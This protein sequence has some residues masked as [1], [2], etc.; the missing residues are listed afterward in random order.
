M[1]NLQKWGFMRL[2]DVYD[3]RVADIEAERIDTAVFESAMMFSRDMQSMMD[4]LVER[5]TVREGSFDLPTAG[6][7]QPLSEDGTPR[8]T[9]SYLTIT[10][11]YPMW[12]GGDSFGLNR[13]AYAVLTVREMEKLMV[14]VLSK[15]ARW[16]I[17]RML[18]AIF[19]NVSYTFVEKGRTNLT[20][21]PLA[22]TADGSIYMDF[23]GDLTTANHYTGQA[24]AISNSANPY[25]AN[26]TILRAHPANTGTIIH[27]I[28]S[29]LVAD[30]QALASFYPYR[31][32]DGLVTYG[33]GVDLAAESVARYIGFGNEVL[34]VVGDG[35]IVLSRRLPAGYV[36]SLVDGVEKPLIMRQEPVATLQGLQSVAI[37]VDSNF[38]KWDFYEKAGFAVQNPI[39]MAVREIEDATYDIPTNYDARTLPG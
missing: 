3:R 8:P 24:D 25:T 18:A 39:A 36:V 22:V 9:Q 19:T 17:R 10:Q 4:T 27:Y 34:G 11:G 1:A 26:E 16:N 33:D 14:G 30:T 32:N 15:S 29:G 38:R 35:V 21:R 12:R 13:E 31:P 5:K 20:V 2:E 6:E 37:Q 23:N 28:P 7:M